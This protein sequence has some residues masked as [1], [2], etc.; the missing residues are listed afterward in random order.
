MD[1]P[2]GLTAVAAESDLRV[3]LEITPKIQLNIK[4]NNP[5]Y[6]NRH[7]KQMLSD[8]LLHWDGLKKE[9]KVKLHQKLGKIY[10]KQIRGLVI[11][12]LKIWEA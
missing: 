5:N 2:S 1:R 3:E 11:Q 7:L 10:T 12:L 9:H 8:P 4:L 6:L